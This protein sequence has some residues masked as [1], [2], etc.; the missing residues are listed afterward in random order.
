MFAGARLKILPFLFINGRV[1][2]TFRLDTGSYVDGQL[3][4]SG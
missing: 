1:Y 3:V 2:Q 4:S